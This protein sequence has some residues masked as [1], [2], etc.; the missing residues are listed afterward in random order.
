MQ[1][2]KN[3]KKAEQIEKI[4]QS[5]DDITY[6]IKR[7]MKK[8]DMKSVLKP[9]DVLK[10]SGTLVS[11]I[12]MTLIILPF[13]TRGTIWDL[14]TNGLNKDNEGKKDSFYELKNNSKISWRNLLF[15]MAKRFQ[16]LV[17]STF[18]ENVNLIRALIIDD[19]T[20][21]KTGKHIEGTGYVHDHVSG[22][23]ILGFKILVLGYWD[24]VSFIPIDF[25][26]HR[27][28]RDDKLK[29]AQKRIAKKKKQIKQLQ[30]RK[31][32]IVTRIAKTKKQLKTSIK[33]G[34]SNTNYN[35]NLLINKLEYISHIQG[36]NSLHSHSYGNNF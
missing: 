14:F 9:F 25:S 3:T 36:K 24:G 29:K 10:R 6:N 31:K 28:K 4:S 27:E 15:G 16:I 22:R 5:E 34:T 33:K 7:V 13:I 18:D 19:T 2:N 26:I 21:A 32:E 23:F 8:F 20:A 11:S 17:S 1:C 30:N 35:S 12:T